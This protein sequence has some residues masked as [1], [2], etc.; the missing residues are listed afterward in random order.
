M[1]LMVFKLGKIANVQ[2]CWKC[3]LFSLQLHGNPIGIW[4]YNCCLCTQNRTRAPWTLFLDLVE[5]KDWGSPSRWTDGQMHKTQMIA[6]DDP[7]FWAKTEMGWFFFW[8][9]CI[10]KQILP[11]SNHTEGHLFY[12]LGS[13]KTISWTPLHIHW[14]FSLLWNSSSLNHVS[15]QS[16][17]TC[18]VFQKYLLLHKY[19]CICG[20]FSCYIGCF[21]VLFTSIF[22]CIYC[23]T[24]SSDSSRVQKNLI[25]EDTLQCSVVFK[26]CCKNLLFIT[27]AYI[28]NDG[29]F[30]FQHFHWFV[31]TMWWSA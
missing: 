21:M 28:A 7:F 12:T 19:L 1:T 4:L 31:C 3:L 15:A 10:R 30:N 25:K 27:S 29:A 8:I 20:C 24:G 26:W 13:L 5:R 22:W 2:K 6:V 9:L 16:N 11:Y 14:V 18:W 17:Q 23:F